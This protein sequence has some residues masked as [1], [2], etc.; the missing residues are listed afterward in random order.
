MNQADWQDG[1][2]CGLCLEYRW[3]GGDP[4]GNGLNPPPS[5]WTYAAV[6]DRCP[7]CQKGSLDLAT[8]GEGFYNIEWRAS[9]CMTGGSPLMY[10]TH[11]SSHGFYTKL[12][13]SNGR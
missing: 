4:G 13:V 8:A 6:C 7:E 11:P 12:K 9:Q 3:V 1:G 2:A 10:W 5:T